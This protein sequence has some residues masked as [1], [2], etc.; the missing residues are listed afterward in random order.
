M[1]EGLM[2]KLTDTQL[3]TLS[4]AL[5]RADGAVIIPETLKGAAAMTFARRLI[6]LR[7]VRI[8]P[9]T[10]DM[11]VWRRTEEGEAEALV[12]TDTAYAAMGVF[13]PPVA[14][15]QSEL[16][17]W[18]ANDARWAAE[19]RQRVVPRTGPAP[20]KR[21]AVL[22]LLRGHAGATMAQMEQATGWQQHSIRAFL[23]GLRKAGHLV[24]R[25]Q[26]DGA[27]VYRVAEPDA[28]ATAADCEA[29]AA[30]TGAAR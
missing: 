30:T 3:V 2:V 7:L 24:T 28:S 18:V 5:K 25:A 10:A 20:G 11:P 1:K 4:R 12:I 27:T 6:D 19:E 16:D 17:A 15:T 13:T 8:V 9:A 22:E 14:P 26:H 29:L 23:S 21:T